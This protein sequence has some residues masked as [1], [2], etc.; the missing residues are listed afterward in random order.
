MKK[1]A[2]VCILV[3]SLISGCQ[4]TTKNMGGTME[5]TLEPNKK[6]EMITWKDDSLWYLTREMREDEE[7]EIHIF[8]QS[9][10]LGVFEGS[11][12]IVESKEKTA[13]NEKE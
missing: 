9:S 3:L 7:P 1:R 8:R 4:S 2:A 6:L 10:E 12:V 5:L 13:Q 11:V